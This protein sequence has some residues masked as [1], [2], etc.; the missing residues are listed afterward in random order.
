MSGV[1]YSDHLHGVD[2]AALKT[3][4]TSDHFDNGRSPDELRL[5]FARSY[6]VC[7]AWFEDRVVGTTRLLSDG[8]CNA[9]LL[10][11][12]T[13]SHLRRR[14]IGAGMVTRLLATAP[15]QHVALFT[16]DR[17]DFY[18][19]LGFDEERTGMSLVVGNWLNRAGSVAPN[20]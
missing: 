7:M 4:L 6:A 17:V 19:A 12:W 2:W 3:D 14:G 5:S 9:Y 11:V 13:T 15:G 18:R 20:A 10:D 8:I 1:R 16:E